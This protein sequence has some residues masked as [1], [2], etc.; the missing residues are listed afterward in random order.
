MKRKLLNLTVRNSVVKKNKRGNAKM[1]NISV[2]LDFSTF[3]GR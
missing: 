1:K 2:D 3:A